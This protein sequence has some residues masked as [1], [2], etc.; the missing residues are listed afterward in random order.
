MRYDCTPAVRDHRVNAGHFDQSCLSGAQRHCRARRDRI[1]QPH[2]LGHRTNLVASCLLGESHRDR[3][4]GS[5]QGFG[6][7]HRS[8]VFSGVVAGR[9]A[10]DSDGSVLDDIVRFDAGFQRRC[11]DNRFE[12]AARL[13]LCLCR[14]IELGGTLLAPANHGHDGAIGTHYD[15]SCLSLRAGL[16]L[17]VENICQCPLG[18]RLDAGVERRLD[19][20]VGAFQQLQE[21]ILAAAI[22]Q[23]VGK[24]TA[25]PCRR[26]LGQN[27][28][29]G[30]R[31]FSLIQCDSVLITHQADN[32]RGSVL[33]ARQVIRRRQRR[34]CT[35]QT[36]QHGSL[37]NRQN[38][39]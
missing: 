32:G 1:T 34:G 23:P 24:S 3:V 31:R 13:T 29:S 6:H 27:R 36:S 19:L 4:D 25:G 14:A 30:Q 17:T 21:P 18:N 15:D 26:R 22:H 2:S 33:A 11:E 38:L 10:L 28:G 8:H 39:G 5:F 20:D 7:C 12:G 9:P 16:D 35:Q 37:G